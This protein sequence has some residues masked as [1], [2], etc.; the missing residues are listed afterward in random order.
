[1]RREAE[2]ETQNADSFVSQRL[3]PD[4]PPYGKSNVFTKN[5]AI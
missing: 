1:V 2:L 4:V 3:T 5:T